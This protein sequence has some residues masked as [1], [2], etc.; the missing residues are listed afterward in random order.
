MCPVWTVCHKRLRGTITVFEV[1]PTDGSEGIELP[2][3]LLLA[4][5]PLAFNQRLSCLS[6]LYPNSTSVFFSK[7][8]Q[9]IYPLFD[10]GQRVVTK[11]IYHLLS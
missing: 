3:S 7:L 6:N 5:P 9:F 8:F 10:L 2:F 4:L 1:L 11:P